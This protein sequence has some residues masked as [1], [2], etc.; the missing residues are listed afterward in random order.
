MIVVFALLNGALMGKLGYFFPWYLFGGGM[1]VIGAALMYTV[2]SNTSTS[3]V[4][5]Y[6]VL[7]GIGVGSFLQASF[8]VSQALVSPKEI[9]D[10]VGL[11]SVGQSVGIVL[12]L[13][14]AGAIYQNESYHAI[15]PL[16]PPPVTPFDVRSLIAGTNSEVFQNLKETAK[17]LVIKALIKTMDKVYILT[18]AGGGLTFVLGLALP[19]QKKTSNE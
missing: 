17:D 5:G 7:L 18:I 8:G 11:I 16:L 12:S 4:Y 15:T 3:A 10:A 19:R 1:S 2:D 6:S 14:M 13:A 9:S